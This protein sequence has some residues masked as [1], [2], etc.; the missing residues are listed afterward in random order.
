MAERVIRALKE[1]F[2]RVR[3][4]NTIKELR[5]TLLASKKQF[6]RRWLLLWHRYATPNQARATYAPVAKAG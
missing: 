1:Q 4:F 3:T 2:L 5:L 6:S